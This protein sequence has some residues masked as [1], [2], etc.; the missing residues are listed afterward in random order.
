[1]AA[2]PPASAPSS[3]SAKLGAAALFVI[4]F[5]VL[6][7]LLVNKGSAVESLSLS[8]KDGITVNFAAGTTGAS[9]RCSISGTVYSDHSYGASPL[10]GVE[11]GYVRSGESVASPEY[12]ATTDALGNFVGDCSSAE[13][14][15]QLV[16][17][18]K[19]LFPNCN[20]ASGVNIPK[21]GQFSGIQLHLSVGILAG[22]PCSLSDRPQ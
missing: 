4:G 12:L 2:E 20:F 18:S 17:S 16:V 13:G 19:Q 11:V 8:P 10:S 7:V 21:S 14:T 6:V 5:V 3:Q 9:G 1:M 15:S 22:L